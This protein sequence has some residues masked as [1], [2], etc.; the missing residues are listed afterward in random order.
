MDSVDDNPY[1][2]PQS[3]FAIP[4]DSRVEPITGQAQL[5][6]LPL[7]PWRIN[8]MLAN[9]SPLTAI[10]LGYVSMTWQF[11]MWLSVLFHGL[12]EPYKDVQHCLFEL[13]CTV[14][15]G[16]G[17]GGVFLLPIA[18]FLGGK[19][20]VTR[21]MLLVP[22]GLTLLSIPWLVCCFCGNLASPH[23][24]ILNDNR[25]AWMTHP[26]VL[27]WGH[28]WVWIGALCV[29]WLVSVMLGRFGPNNQK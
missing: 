13:A 16:L 18:P 3:E 29:Y 17:W 15:L 21:R 5:F 11:G 23:Y 26:A 2:S 28:S 19:T 14:P 7:M 4:P 24:G 6:S 10:A 9:C 25:P 20:A 1:E 12:S 8:S 22:W 27:L